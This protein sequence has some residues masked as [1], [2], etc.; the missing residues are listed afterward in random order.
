MLFLFADT[1]ALNSYSGLLLKN[2]DLGLSNSSRLRKFLLEELILYLIKPQIERRLEKFR[3]QDFRGC[4]DH[5]KVSISRIGYNVAVNRDRDLSSTS[6]ESESFDKK[7][8][9]CEQELCQNKNRHYRQ[10]QECKM[11]C[12][13][14]H[15]KKI[16]TIICKK[17]VEK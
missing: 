9:R 6:S 11:Y 7:R 17:C 1:S 2:P 13:P 5:I 16:N 8:K 14:N 15:S 10:C 4:Q 12:C 3:T